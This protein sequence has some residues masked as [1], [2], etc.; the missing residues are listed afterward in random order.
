MKFV[1]LLYIRGMGDSIAMSIA[2]RE[3]G[4]AGYA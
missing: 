4:L 3:D 2:Y 1:V